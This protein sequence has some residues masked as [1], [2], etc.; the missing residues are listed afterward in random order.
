MGDDTIKNDSGWPDIDAPG[1]ASTK[2]ALHLYT[3][4]LGKIR[5]ALSPAQPNWMFTPLLF[6]A[7]GVTTGAVPVGGVAV[8]GILDV[9]TSEIVVRTSRGDERH[10]GLMRASNVA[11]VYRALL[12]SLDELKI[13]CL[14][15]PVPQEIPDTTP[16][17][18]DTRPVAYEPRDAQRWFRAAISAAGVFERWRSHFFGRSGVQLW[19]GAFDVAVVLFNGKHA[20]PPTNR[21]YLMR[22][23]LDAELMNAGLYFGDEKTKPFFYGYIYPQPAEAPAIIVS[24]REASWSTTFSEWVLP[25]D[26]VR[27]ADDPEATLRAFLDSIYEVCVS[28]AGWNRADLSYDAPKRS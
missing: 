24:P 12:A 18:E 13:S 20:S 7:H 3:Q 8:E 10:I 22:Y 21:G 16:L 28:K 9:F 14:I 26:A 1:W 15:S 5:V 19:W 27:V 6:T 11:E 17:P 2:K 25:Y 23:D 4:M